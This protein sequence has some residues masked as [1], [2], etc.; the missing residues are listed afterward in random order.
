M[1]LL[2]RQRKRIIFYQVIKVLKALK[3][4]K[5][6]LLILFFSL[7]R[8]RIKFCNGQAALAYIVPLAITSSDAMTG[9]H[10]LI[11]KCCE[12]VEISTYSNR[13]RKIFDS[14]DQRVAI[15]ILQKNKPPTSLLSTKVNKRYEN[16][17]IQDVIDNLQFVNSLEFAKYGRLPKIGS[18]IEINIL[19][20]VFN[21]TKI[22]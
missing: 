17:S 9:L 15:I 20:K 8:K 12:T 10:N 3:V 6:A 19:K 21:S 22:F 14:A 11:F 5:K 18:Q 7:F 1:G 2:V 13:P 4:Y 16:T